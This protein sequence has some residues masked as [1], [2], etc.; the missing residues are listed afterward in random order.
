MGRVIISTFIRKKET[1]NGSDYDLDIR[2]GDTDR[3]VNLIVGTV[4]S[5]PEVSISDANV[6]LLGHLDFTH[7]AVSTSER[8]KVDNP[9]TDGIICLSSN[10]A[11]ICEVSSTG[12]HVNG[13]STETSDGRLKEN[14][15]K[16]NSK[17][18]YDIVKYI[19]PQEFNSNW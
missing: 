17:P 2:N 7:S 10:A 18:C 19:R 1:L 4:G 15:S 11:N 8:V 12:L 3:A 16:I 14:L 13:T 6:N 9:D 5:T